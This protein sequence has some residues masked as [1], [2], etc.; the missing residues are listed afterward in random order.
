MPTHHRQLTH[1]RVLLAVQVAAVF[2]ASV[3]AGLMLSGLAPGGLHSA[4]SYTIFVVAVLQLVAAIR[5]RRAGG[6]AQPIRYSIGFGLAVLAQ[7]FV[8]IAHLTALHIP[9]GMLLFGGIVFQLGW[10]LDHG[11]VPTPAAT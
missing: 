5:L 3:T 9:L 6:P 2:S 4:A 10:A 1:L 11:R 7:V 8:G